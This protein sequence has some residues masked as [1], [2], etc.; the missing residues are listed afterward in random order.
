MPK[1]IYQAILIPEED[2]YNVEV[3]DLPGCFSFGSNYQEAVFMAADAMKTY[4]SSL[5]RHGEK[6]PLPTRTLCDSGQESVQIFFE[7]DDQYLVEG[8]VVSAS[9]AAKMLGVSR[10]RV[11]HLLSAGLLVGYREGRST[12]VSVESIEKRLLSEPSAGRPRKEA[13]S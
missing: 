4:V 10:G 6:I 8:E 2:G 5:I 12:F 1:F 7:T 11:T 13:V 3:P 9:Q